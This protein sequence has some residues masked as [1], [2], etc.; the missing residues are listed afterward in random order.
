MKNLTLMFILSVVFN[1]AQ[2][3]EVRK[4]VV[5][6]EF[7]GAMV[8]G[9]GLGYERYVPVSPKINVTGRAGGGLVRSFT[10]FSPYIGGSILYGKR[11]SLEIGANGIF[12]YD[13]EVME[14]S[15]SIDSD[16]NQ[17]ALQL[18]MG[19]RYKN[20]DNGIMFRVFLVP[21]IGK[22][23]NLFGFPYAGLSLGYAF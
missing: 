5:Y 9:I 6:T 11:S 10:A 4:N 16:H 7:S 19:Y 3:Q 17:E 2:A 23:A 14:D 12:N 1:I 8:A 21:P 20:E 15:D 18:L 13:P 22:F